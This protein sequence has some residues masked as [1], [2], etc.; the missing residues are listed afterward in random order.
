MTTKMKRYSIAARL[1][2]IIVVK[3]RSRRE[4]LEFAQ[5][6][7]GE[8]EAHEPD[9]IYIVGSLKDGIAVLDSTGTGDG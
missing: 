8:W 9:E 2:G 5:N 1:P 3:A 6:G 4:A 7:A